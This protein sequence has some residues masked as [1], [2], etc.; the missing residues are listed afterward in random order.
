MNKLIDKAVKINN[1][2][3]VSGR[4]ETD[5]AD[6]LKNVAYQIR[7]ASEYTVMV[8]GTESN[9]KAG[10]MVT[11]SDDLVKGQNID[12][13]SIIRE[14]SGEINGGGGG[15]PFLATAGGKSPEGIPRALAKAAEFL[16]KY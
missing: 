9:G 6:V 16:R 13:V 5:S 4:I 15:Q 11:V 2:K 10:L 7:T 8:I 12:A 3:Y 1:I 14:I